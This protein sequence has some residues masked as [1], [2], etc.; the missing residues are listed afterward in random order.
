VDLVKNAETIV[1][2]D[3]KSSTNDLTQE[4]TRFTGRG[5][6]FNSRKFNNRTRGKA[7]SGYDF[8]KSSHKGKMTTLPYKNIDVGSSLGNL[9]DRNRVKSASKYVT[10]STKMASR[11]NMNFLS[12]H[13]NKKLE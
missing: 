2:C 9:K 10:A 6:Q 13:L 5:L 11:A 3:I 7:Q 12:G 4:T 1:N 8:V